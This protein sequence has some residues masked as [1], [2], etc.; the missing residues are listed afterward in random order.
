M[1]SEEKL[2]DGGRLELRT[3]D[4]REPGSVSRFIET[5]R[6]A[7]HPFELLT[8]DTYGAATPGA[9]ENS[10]E[11]T[12]AAMAAAARIRDALAATVCL[13]HHTNASA[14]RSDAAVDGQ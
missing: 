7:G 12:T 14:T 2:V 6:A 8:V 1:I 3:S 11:D 9:A 4:L 10:S 5:V 13:V